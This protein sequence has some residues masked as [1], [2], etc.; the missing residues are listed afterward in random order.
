MSRIV[1][2]AMLL[3]GAVRAQDARSDAGVSD[4]PLAVASVRHGLLELDDGTTRYVDG[5][6]WLSD[7]T[8]AQRVRDIVRLAAENKVL[9]ETPAPTPV[10][11]AVGLAVGVV[12][13]GA[14]AAFGTFKLCQSTALCQ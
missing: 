13:G 14:G 9:R 11:V 2:T 3:A 12:L 6:V 7:D 5:G 4:V 1:L 8:A 10:A